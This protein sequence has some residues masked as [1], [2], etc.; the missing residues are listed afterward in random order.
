LDASAPPCYLDDAVPVRHV[1]LAASAL[2]V[3][4]LAVFLF[5]EVRSSPAAPTVKATPKPER[6]AETTPDHSEDEAP[7]PVRTVAAAG[8]TSPPPTAR[9]PKPDAEVAPALPSQPA[10]G[11]EGTADGVKLEALMAEA[12]KAYDKMD[13]DEARTIAQKV[14]KQVPGNARMLRI[15]VS[16]ACIENDATEAQ[17]H[18][19]LLGKADREQMKTRCSRYGVAFTD[20][21]AK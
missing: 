21:P 13:F 4:G 1:I 19:N 5:L 17:K 18:Y 15:M 10:G 14:L 11:V 8:N 7:A 12:N 6:V 2:L 3:L 16:A 9:P 20:P